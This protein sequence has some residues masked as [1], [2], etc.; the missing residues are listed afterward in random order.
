M[1]LILRKRIAADKRILIIVFY[2]V[3][4]FL[5]LFFD[6]PINERLKSTLYTIVEFS[7]FCLIIYQQLKAKKQKLITLLLYFVFLVLQ[8]IHYFN[9]KRTRLDSIPIGIETILIFIFITFYVHEQL[10]DEKQF[11]STTNYFFLIIIG[12]LI[13]LGGSFFIYLLANNL[14]YN[15]LKTY[16]PIT[17]IVELIKNI[18][19][20]IAIYKFS[21]ELNKKKKKNIDNNLPNLDFTL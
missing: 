12:L 1:Y 14:D 7:F 15:E 8:V 21:V 13:Y 18:L 2:S 16:W 6:P 17:Y 3:C 9:F 4:I 10:K 5:I 19:F 11:F 20:S